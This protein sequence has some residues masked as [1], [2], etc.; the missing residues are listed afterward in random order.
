[1]DRYYV[2]YESEYLEHDVE[3]KFMLYDDHLAV[4]QKLEERVRELEDETQQ[5]KRFA[6]EEASRGAAYGQKVGYKIGYDNAML[7]FSTEH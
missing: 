3:G 4:V 1:M 6:Q 2:R 7:K 5:L